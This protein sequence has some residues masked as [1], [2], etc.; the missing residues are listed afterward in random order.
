MLDD[1]L[2]GKGQRLFVGRVGNG[3]LDPA[4]AQEVPSRFPMLG[5]RCTPTSVLYARATLLAAIFRCS[6]HGFPLFEQ[7]EQKPT[8]KNGSFARFGGR[9]EC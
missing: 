8:L 6:G 9:C 4:V 7:G 3:V 2:L 1:K 5:A